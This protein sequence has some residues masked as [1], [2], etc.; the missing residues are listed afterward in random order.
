MLY[1]R[2]VGGI[3]VDGD[4]TVA[5]LIGKPIEQMRGVDFCSA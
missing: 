1:S 4:E 3:V 5:S 2:V